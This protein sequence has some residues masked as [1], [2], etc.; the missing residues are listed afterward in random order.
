MCYLVNHHLEFEEPLEREE[1][2]PLREIVQNI[3][4]DADETV[5]EGWKN[6]GY[7]FDGGM[8]TQFCAIAPLKTRV[9]LYFP[10]GV[11]LDDPTGVLEGS[12]KRMRHIKVTT[13]DQ[14]ESDVVKALIRQAAGRNQV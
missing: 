11:D 1:V 8:K 9:K 14:A 13:T 6:V 5:R 2:A 7:S 12:G 10:D 3:V 4:P